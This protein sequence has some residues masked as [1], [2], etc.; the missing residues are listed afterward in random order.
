MVLTEL[1][2]F[3]FSGVE[4]IATIALLLVAGNYARKGARIG[5]VLSTAG[6]F[7]I[8]LGVLALT[9]V[10][11]IDVGALGGIVGAALDLLSGVVPV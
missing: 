11:S 10:V 6:I 9:G 4:G 1:L 5:D 2:S 7:A 8:V 3:V